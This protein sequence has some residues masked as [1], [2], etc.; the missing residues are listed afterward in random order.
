MLNHRLLACALATLAVTPAVAQDLAPHR[1]VYTVSPMERGKASR[2]GSIGTYGYEL[3]ATCEGYTVNQRMRIEIEGEG[4]RTPIVSEQ[5]SQMTESRD[6]TKFHFEHRS[7]ANGKQTSLFKG[8]ALLDGSIGQARFGEP[9]GQTVALPAETLFPVAISRATL[10]HAKAGDGGF[11]GLFFFGDKVKP[12]QAANILIGKVPKRLADIA[13]PE[14]AG[15]LVEGRERIYFRAGFFDA[16]AKG[17]GEPAFEMSSITLDNG[18]EL[19][20]TNEQADT[21]IEYRLTRLEAL[22]KPSCN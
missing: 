4:G 6:G 17:Q 8:D 16:A 18:V 19:Y 20:G 11:D 14:G 3:R 7:T 1:A 10:R 21:A 9:E 5:Q 15:A 22:P 2:S 13:I 12:P